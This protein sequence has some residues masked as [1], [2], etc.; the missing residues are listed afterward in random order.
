[1]PTCW[2]LNNLAPNEKHLCGAWATTLQARIPDAYSPTCFWKTDASTSSLC[3]MRRP[4]LP[5]PYNYYYQRAGGATRRKH[6]GV[7]ATSL[8]TAD[9]ALG[10]HE[11]MIHTHLQG[12]QNRCRHIRPW[13]H[14]AP[15]SA[16]YVHLSLS[17]RC[18]RS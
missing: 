15:S 1:M 17:E 13:H 4:P 18:R 16:C 2:R 6:F 7:W 12:A 9:V 14:A 10:E 3:N 11:S 8:Q 5:A